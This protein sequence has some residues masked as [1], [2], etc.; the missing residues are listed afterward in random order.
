M[1]PKIGIRAIIDGR[2]GG[3]RESLEDVC[4]EMAYKAKRIIESDCFYLDG[5]SVECVIG[6]TTIGGF[7]EASQ[8][9][10]QFSKENVI[11]T[12]SVTSCWCYGTETM[13]T[14]PMTIKAIWGLNNP[15]RPGAVYLA[16][17]MAAHAQKGIPAFA[18]YGEDVQ[19]SDEQDVPN[20]VRAK[21]VQFAQCAI[22]VGQLR[23]RAYVNIGGV[24]M[25]IMGSYCDH[26][27]FQEYLGLRPE[28]V[29]MS[30]IMRRVQLNIFD[31]EEY[32]KALAWVKSNCIEGHDK[33]RV[34]KTREEL[35]RDWEY[36][37]KMTLILRDIIRGNPRLKAL[38]WEEES[39][40]HCGAYGGFQGQRQWTDFMPNGDFAEAILNSSFDWNG[41]RQ[42]LIVATENDGLNGTAMYFAQALTGQPVVFADV[43]TYWS[44]KS[45][46]RFTGWAPEGLAKDGFI[47]LINSGSAALDGIGVCENEQGEHCI[48]PW[49]KTSDDEHKKMLELTQFCPADR[50][51]FRGGGFSSRFIT[52]YEM[53]LTLIRVNIIDGIGP[54]IQIGEGYSCVVPEKVADTIWK[55]TDYTWPTTFFVPRLLNKTGFRNVHSF[56]SQWGSNHGAFVYGHIGKELI[57]LASMLRIPVSLHNV[58]DESIYRPHSYSGFGTENLEAADYLASKHYG[59]LYK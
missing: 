35:A 28:F 36:S 57:T 11:A 56:M 55:L 51:Y 39:C 40:G 17:A 12:L 32:Q 27:F 15:S 41:K 44:P 58:D 34:K 45:I 20:D 53:P 21:I 49:W 5:S 18:I 23:H 25:G 52:N 7:A 59:P 30:E 9:E 48:K 29:D 22:A 46:E 2:R 16:A 14:N 1:K 31:P 13:D 4:M 24:S 54:V 8:I 42:P 43:R 47:H 38:G 6:N 50:D 26:H 3:I 19:N 10:N 33:N 37:V